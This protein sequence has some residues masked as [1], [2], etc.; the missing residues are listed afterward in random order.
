LMVGR[1]EPTVRLSQ[2]R[3]RDVLERTIRDDPK[4]PLSQPGR[5]RPEDR[6]RQ[7]SG[8]GARSLVAPL[9]PPTTGLEPLGRHAPI[10]VRRGTVEKPDRVLQLLAA[11]EIVDVESVFRQL[12]DVALLAPD[13]IFEEGR[14]GLEGALAKLIHGRSLRTR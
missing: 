8:R 3:E 1:E 10:A 13:E 7:I 12:E 14:A 9:Q 5:H 11:G 2:R 6:A 4:R